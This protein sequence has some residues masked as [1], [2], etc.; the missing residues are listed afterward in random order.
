[1][2][3]AEALSPEAE[4]APAQ[5]LLLHRGF[6]EAVKA[7]TP[8]PGTSANVGRPTTAKICLLEAQQSSLVKFHASGFLSIVCAPH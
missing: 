3:E 5:S 7:L 2:S 4:A 8:D 1:M 6:T